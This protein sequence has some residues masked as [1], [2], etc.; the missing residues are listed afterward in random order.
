MDAKDQI[1]HNL[2]KEIELLKVENQ[3]LKEQL[4]RVTQ[5]QPIEMPDFFPNKPKTL[6]PLGREDSERQSEKQQ[7]VPINKIITEYQFEI[8]RLMNENQELRSAQEMV[9]RNYGSLISDNTTIQ[10]KLANL[11]Q[12]FLSDAVGGKNNG[13]NEEYMT[14]NL[15]DENAQLKGHVRNLEEKKKHM[16]Q[17]LESRGNE[18]YEIFFF[19]ENSKFFKFLT[20]LRFYCDACR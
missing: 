2:N 1:I 20:I 17:I 5:G 18:K 7:E 11:E 3:Y 14:K 10:A 16:E 6:P 4:Q 13:K 9:E 19:F 15:I 8:Q 12:V